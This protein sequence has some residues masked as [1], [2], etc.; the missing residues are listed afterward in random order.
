ML[1]VRTFLALPLP[2]S[3]RSYLFELP[4]HITNSQDKI[5]WVRSENIH[6]TLIF[7]GDT[8]PDRIIQQGH[9]IRDVINRKN[10]IKMGITDTGIFPHAN[11]PRVLWVG[12]APDDPAA[13]KSLTLDLRELMKEL[14]YQLDN[15]PSQAHITL[16]RVKTISR[17]SAFTHDFLATEVRHIQ[18]VADEVKWYKSTL[19]PAGAVYEELETFK[20]KTGGQS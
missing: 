19:T 8:D 6:I 20:L 4:R 15:R 11:D 13:F 3:L 7:L 18:F 12:S 14:G 17:N 1:A 2:A 5:N 9:L 16:G 10:A